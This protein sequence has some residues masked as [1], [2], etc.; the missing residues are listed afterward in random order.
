MVSERELE[1]AYKAVANRKRIA[2]VRFLKSTGPM[3]VGDIASAIKLSFKA[4]SRHLQI[5]YSAG[6][7]ISEREGIN[8]RYALNPQSEHVSRVVRT[9][10]Q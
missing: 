5:L 10:A 3:T 6:F 9:L 1:R 7:L 4:T 2:V 8:V